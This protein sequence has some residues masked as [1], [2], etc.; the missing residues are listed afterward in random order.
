MKSESDVFSS[1]EVVFS[2]IQ[3][4]IVNKFDD[5]QTKRSHLEKSDTTLEET[6]R[7]YSRRNVST[8]NL[9][10]E[11]KLR[12]Y[13]EENGDD[14]NLK[15]LNNVRIDFETINR[16]A[17]VLKNEL[18]LFGT[19]FMEGALSVFN[20]EL[21]IA[22]EKYE[23]RLHVI[24]NKDYSTK[25]INYDISFLK[26]GERKILSPKYEEKEKAIKKLEQ[27]EEKQEKKKEIYKSN[28]L[29]NRQNIENKKEEE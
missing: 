26:K 13:F 8:E 28:E 2:G 27:F 21:D 24:E 14:N 20:I 7:E 22:V 29:I 18:S 4:A 3:S 1:Q 10:T 15:V 25:K 11:S 6:R 5:E 16:S 12:K 23:N 19:S 17:D 9:V